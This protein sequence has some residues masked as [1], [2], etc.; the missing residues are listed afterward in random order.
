[1]IIRR[2][3]ARDIP[4]I[5]ELFR[6]TILSVN[7]KDYTL[8]QAH[9]WA[10]KGESTNIWEERIAEQYFIVA[11][12]DNVITGFAALKPDGYL[13]SMF[14]HKDSQH[15]GVASHLLHDVENH[16]MLKGLS[17]ITADVSITAKP[18][19]ERKGYKVLHQQTVNIGVEMVNYKMEKTL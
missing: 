2:A 13:N 6:Q 3:Q 7:T 19:F 8:E 4:Q 11:L 9:C 5:K 18:F 17:M 10:S 1:M 16:A 14:V 15:K 12:T